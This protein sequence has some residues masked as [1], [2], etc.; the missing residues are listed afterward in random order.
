MRE[1]RCARQPVRFTSLGVDMSGGLFC[2]P[3]PKM[4]RAPAA[5]EQEV[6]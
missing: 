5:E 2:A 6:T 4:R 1:E 3:A